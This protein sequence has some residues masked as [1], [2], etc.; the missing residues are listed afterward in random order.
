MDLEVIS[1][2][3]PY[4]KLSKPEFT[5]VRG[6]GHFKK[7]KVWQ[8]IV[9]EKPGGKFKAVVKAL[10]LRHLRDMSV[11]FLKADAEYPGCTITTREQFANLINSLRAPFWSQVGLDTELTIITLATI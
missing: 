3:H 7:L 9:C 5:T 11:D 2:R 6:K 1:F 8:T 10:E 4:F